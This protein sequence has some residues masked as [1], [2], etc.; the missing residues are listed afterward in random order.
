MNASAP[1]K[2]RGGSS[3][4]ATRGWKTSTLLAA[5]L[6]V[7]LGLLPLQA[8]A[9]PDEV[10]GQAGNADQ[11]LP[12]NM[13]T[14]LRSVQVVNGANQQRWCIATCSADVRRPGGLFQSTLFTITLNAPPPALDGPCERT[15]QFHGDTDVGI[16]EVTTTCGPFL[17]PPTT[18]FMRCWANP[19]M[20]IAQTA[21][22]SS[23]TVTCT[24][25]RTEFVP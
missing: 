7:C 18:S 15:V 11:F 1:T 6:P 24:D 14:P 5:A 21:L 20:G 9:A 17:T 8:E 25:T 19:V 10:G 16:K 23:M 13:W 4:P 12:F 22:D 2:N 3:R